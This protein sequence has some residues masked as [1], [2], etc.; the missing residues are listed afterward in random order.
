MSV[1]P[2]RK[3]EQPLQM[4]SPLSEIRGIGA[5]TAQ[6]YAARGLFTASDLLHYYPIAYDSYTD[7]VLSS[8]AQPG[9]VTALML[10]VIGSGVT[11]HKAGHSVTYF[12]AADAG[13][14]VRLTYFNM[15]YL[16][17]SV[18]P[19]STYVFRAV[20][21]QSANGNLYM[22]QPQM[23]SP[24]DYEAVRGT[25]QPRYSLTQG[26]KN[27]QIRKQVEQILD[28]C[29]TADR[30]YLPPEDRQRL[31]LTEEAAA[32]RAVHFPE[33]REE[34]AAA[35]ER[36]VFDEFFFFLLAIDRE[37]GK[38]EELRN[39]RP[40]IETA[41]PGRLME[42]L[43]YELTASQK[44]AYSE[45]RDDLC[46]P[47]VMNRLLQGDVGSG[48]TIV[49]FLAL[50]L[51]AAN[52]R[53]GAMMVPTEVL[54]G[55]HM[56]DL[57]EM[58]KR[59]HLPLHPVLLTGSVTGT[60]RKQAY[61]EIRT[62][63]ANVIIGTHALIQE[64][65]EYQD[66]GL[67]VTD[68]QHRFGVRQRE[69]LAGKGEAVPILVMSATP[70]PRTLALILYVDL[71]VSLLTETPRNRLP[72]K[73]TVLDRDSWRDKSW[74]FILGQVREGRQAY[75]ICPEVEEGELDGVENV[76]DYT[77]KLKAAFP[78]DIRINAL[79]GRMKPAEKD[80]IMNDFA[81]HRTDIL[82]STTVIEVGIS[83]ANATVMMI[84]NAE[85]F[86]LAQL[87]QLRGRVGRGAAQSYCIFLYSG[88]AGTEKPKR[89]EILGKSDDGFYIAEQD[90]K[91][92][93]P[94]DLF[95]VRQSGVLGFELADIY[96]DS[97]VLKKAADYAAELH[98]K[99]CGLQDPSHRG[100]VERLTSET[101][102]QVDFRTI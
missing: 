28:A 35:H 47:F 89:L 74:K 6:L 83:V 62:G 93:G 67:V 17:K 86:G 64:K 38:A 29:E 82:V 41:D 80:R 1:S 99:D 25:L 16:K 70:I 49:A 5:K 10:T 102:K 32:E 20:L 58:T 14:Q 59:Y 75:I 76:T 79:T 85:R 97:G 92:R 87:H 55:Q 96:E 94:G 72:I 2:R 30:E 88:D 48:K 4:Q 24:A 90:L 100:I 23:I 66:L 13:G 65:L 81:D 8:A 15:P 44:K 61:E 36:L 56:R 31:G 57:V 11:F 3:N 37:K 69:S 45:I 63:Q 22:E 98:R 26:L 39:P 12:K 52:G 95:G 43:P 77:V 53:Q 40:M 18:R 34:L 42:A 54:A 84:E 78:E 51:T 27:K 9:T 50:L 91:Q 46:G 73:N 71:H 101:A 33:S 7:P 68:E 21:K 19:G 60:A